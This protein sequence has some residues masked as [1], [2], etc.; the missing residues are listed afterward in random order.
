MIK[1]V[2]ESLAYSS[3]EKTDA[4]KFLIE[5]IGSAKSLTTGF[6][7][8]KEASLGDDLGYSVAF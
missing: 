1:V 5:P 8:S 2:K 3:M 6:G 4:L 7:F